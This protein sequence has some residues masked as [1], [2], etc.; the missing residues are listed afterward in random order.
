MQLPTVLRLQNSTDTDASRTRKQ[1][2]TAVTA[3]KFAKNWSRNKLLL[4]HAVR[5]NKLPP[6][7]PLMNSQ[8]TDLGTHCFKWHDV[9]YVQ[10]M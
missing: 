2:A 3:D 6:Q 4:M 7:L 5:G 10:Q 8:K 9:P 1:T